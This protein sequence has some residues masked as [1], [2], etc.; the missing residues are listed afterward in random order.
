MIEFDHD[1]E[2]KPYAI[3]GRPFDKH[4]DLEQDIGNRYRSDEY[5]HRQISPISAGYDFPQDDRKDRRQIRAVDKHCGGDAYLICG[6]HRPPSSQ[7][8]QKKRQQRPPLQW[9][10]TRL[11][12]YR[13]QQEPGE[14]S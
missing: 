3:V 2:T 11:V 7:P 13:G 12:R 8:K 1:R 6:Q 4:F 9:K 14:D 10:P 5:R